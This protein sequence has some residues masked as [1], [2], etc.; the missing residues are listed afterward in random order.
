MYVPVTY[1]SFPGGK[2]VRRDIHQEEERRGPKRRREEKETVLIF[3]TLAVLLYPSRLVEIDSAAVL[4][5]PHRTL[6][7]I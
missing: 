2:D 6:L 1:A 4:F 3:S 7:L 5:N